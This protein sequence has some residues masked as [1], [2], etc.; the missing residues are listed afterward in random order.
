MWPYLSGKV[1]ESPRN[2]IVHDHRM[3]TDKTQGV[4]RNGKYKL[5]MMNESRAGWYGQFT[6]NSSWTKNMTDIYAGCSADK[7]CLFD[8][9]NDV[10][11]HNDISNQNPEIVKSM[12]QLFHTFDNQY[13]PPKNHPPADTQNYCNSIVA[14]K[15][16][17][18]SWLQNTTI[19]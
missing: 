5:I 9:E 2:I 10:T 15:D 12:T 13:H 6:P 4:I 14:N 3:Y 17:I 7:P 8:I 18:V 1:F 19:T 16:F 11:E